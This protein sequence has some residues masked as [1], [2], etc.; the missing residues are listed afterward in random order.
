MEK[1]HRLAKLFKLEAEDKREYGLNSV[2]IS[3]RK[4]HHTFKSTRNE[5]Y[6]TTSTTAA[7]RSEN[8]EYVFRDIVRTDRLNSYGG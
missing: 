1:S 6:I 4:R 8:K 3:P 2:N 5:H 7:Q